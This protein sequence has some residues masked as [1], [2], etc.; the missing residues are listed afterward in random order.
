MKALEI[1][2]VLLVSVS[3]LSDPV[4]LSGFSKL[5]NL[6]D[7]V[8]NP[9]VMGGLGYAIYQSGTGT[10]R[11]ELKE[12]NLKKREVW[13]NFY[14]KKGQLNDYLIKLENQIELLTDSVS[15]LEHRL[16][17]NS[18][19]LRASVENFTKKDLAES[20]RV[21]ILQKTLNKP[22]FE[23]NFINFGQKH[24]KKKTQRYAKTKAIDKSKNVNK[25]ED[26]DDD[27]KGMRKLKRITR[28][29]QMF[30]TLNKRKD[31]KKIK[32]RYNLS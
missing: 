23:S 31:D 20:E 28:K 19:A 12:L 15:Y 9:L 6:T 2:I 3:V 16:S 5:C 17:S 26:Q 21:K 18:D 8:T 29:L 13:N 4:D 10:Q 22:L 24:H 7:V 27:E 11:R 25:E 32:I 1:G 14:T 30:P